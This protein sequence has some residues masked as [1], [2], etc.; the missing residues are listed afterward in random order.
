MNKNLIVC[1]ICA[2][3]WMGCS[4]NEPLD[5]IYALVS[6]SGNNQAG[7]INTQLAAPLEVQIL[8]EEG[9]I[10]SNVN[11]S[12]HVLEGG[13]SISE[14]LVLS[15]SNGLASVL[16]TVGAVTTSQVVEVSILNNSATP[17]RLHSIAYSSGTLV[18]ARDGKTY[19]TISIGSQTWMAENLNYAVPTW[20]SYQGICSGTNYGRL[21]GWHALMNGNTSRGICPQGWHVPSDTEWNT[22][23]LALGMQAADTSFFSIPPIGTFPPDTIVFITPVARGNHGSLLKSIHGW[24]SNN[25]SNTSGFN[26]Y[27]NGYYEENIW[28]ASAIHIGCGNTTLFWTATKNS[29]TTAMVRGLNANSDGVLRHDNNLIAPISKDISCRCVQD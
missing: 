29:P 5:H 4:K 9:N 21:Y 17:I 18:D 19:A 15:D 16:W 26:A 2:I 13:G 23:E 24:D 6:V 12:F 11:V 20:F 3:L 10:V 27:P 22:L 28:W 14:Q 8:D 1:F 25:G 7:K